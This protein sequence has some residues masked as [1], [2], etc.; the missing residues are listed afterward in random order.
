MFFKF[1]DGHYEKDTLNISLSFSLKKRDHVELLSENN[2]KMLSEE[3]KAEKKMATFS[4]YPIQAFIYVFFFQPEGRGKIILFHTKR[5]KNNVSSHDQLAFLFLPFSRL[6]L[7]KERKMN[8]NPK[9]KRNVALFGFHNE[10]LSWP[11]KCPRHRCLA[12]KG[13]L[14][15]TS[16]FLPITN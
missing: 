2:T 10:K 5:K 6:L 7:V 15:L 16:S 1:P 12:R 14:P 11:S 13:C 3:K 8:N 4:L 9:K